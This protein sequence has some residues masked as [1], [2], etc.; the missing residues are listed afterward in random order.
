MPSL[1]FRAAGADDALS[2]ATLHADSWRR[3]YR[4]AYSDAFL[5]GHVLKDRRS[6]WEARLAAPGDYATIMAEDEAGALIGFVH[7]VFDDHDRWGS[8]VDNLHVTSDRKRSGIGTQLM[9]RAAT[10]V[11]ELARTG[12]M[13]L[14]VLEQN[15]AAQQFYLALGG[16]KVEKTSAEP[17]PAA[18]RP[19]ARPQKF[20]ISWPDAAIITAR[21]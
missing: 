16:T 8:L 21:A 15:T 1:R 11:T 7:V 6:V 10:A 4:G 9:V 13:Y 17:P 19:G 12:A 2:V 20:R 5:D 14:W 3:H 18:A